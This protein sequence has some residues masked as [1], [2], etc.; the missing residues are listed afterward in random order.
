MRHFKGRVLRS[1]FLHKPKD[2]RPR[3]KSVSFHKTEGCVPSSKLKSPSLRFLSIQGCVPSTIQSRVLQVNQSRVL[4]VNQSRV[5]QQI[6]AA[7]LNNPESRLSTNQSCVSQQSRT[8]SSPQS[9]RHFNKARATSPLR[10]PHLFNILYL[11]SFVTPCS[12]MY[13]SQYQYAIR[14]ILLI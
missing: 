11:A 14:R 13:V 5:S 3:C 10:R 4:Q 8:A 9:L 12:L 1:A 7:S 2:A 6:R